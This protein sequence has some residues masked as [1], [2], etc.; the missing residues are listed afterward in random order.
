MTKALEEHIINYFEKVL[1]TA[2]TEC[3][4]KFSA[5]AL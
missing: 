2:G 5:Q 1:G 3:M 4:R